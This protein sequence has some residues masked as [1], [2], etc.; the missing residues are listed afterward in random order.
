[1]ENNNNRGF[2]GRKCP[3]TWMVRRA[4]RQRSAWRKQEEKTT[5]EKQSQSYDFGGR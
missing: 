5:H 1:M 2:D 4:I 3:K